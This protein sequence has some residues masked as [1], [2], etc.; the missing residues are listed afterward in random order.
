[1]NCS[2]RR[3]TLSSFPCPSEQFGK[4]RRQVTRP[5]ERQSGYLAQAFDYAAYL[6]S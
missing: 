6:F 2:S 3:E 4:Q 1:M 5:A